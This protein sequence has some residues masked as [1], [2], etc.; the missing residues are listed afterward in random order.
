[1]NA[2]ADD[3]ADFFLRRR[4]AGLR[5]VDSV[6]RE[7]LW[8]IRAG[9]ARE[10][11]CRIARIRAARAALAGDGLGPGEVSPALGGWDLYHH[12]CKVED[13]Q[14]KGGGPNSTTKDSR[15]AIMRIIF[16]FFL[17]G[18]PKRKDII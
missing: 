10:S 12:Q 16:F 13:G 18:L 8:R 6:L 7:N 14:C 3:G 15:H 11:N 5:R 1:M 9:A 2:K 17:E 4:S